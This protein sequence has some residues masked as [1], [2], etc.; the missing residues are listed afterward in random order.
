VSA[1]FRSFHLDKFQPAFQRFQIAAGF[2]G[3]SSKL[4]ECG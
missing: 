2:Y 1:I 4:P 3:F